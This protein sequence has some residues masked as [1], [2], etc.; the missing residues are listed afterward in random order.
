MGEGRKIFN[1]H[2]SYAVLRLH[3]DMGGEVQAMLLSAWKCPVAD[4]VFDTVYTCFSLTSHYFIPT[5]DSFRVLIKYDLRGRSDKYLAYKR[6]TKILEKWRFISQ[7]SL[8][9]S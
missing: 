5:I 8:I 7:D 2:I 9:F 4:C 1:G 3:R 6:K